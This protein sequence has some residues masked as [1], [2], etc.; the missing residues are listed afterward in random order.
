MV[1]KRGFL[2]IVEAVVAI[3]IVLGA[4]LFVIAQNK[5]NSESGVLCDRIPPLLDEIAKNSSLR[6]A[7]L[8]N[9]TEKISSFIEQRISN[10]LVDFEVFIC[11]AEELCSLQD[12]GFDD[13]EICAGERIIS[14]TAERTEFEPRKLKVFLFRKHSG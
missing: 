9:E 2:R 11:K 5:G 12:G 1:N 3:L 13:I 7:V 6:N 10:P 14:T 4:I 8:N